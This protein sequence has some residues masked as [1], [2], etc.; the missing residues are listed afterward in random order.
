MEKLRFIKKV[1]IKKKMYNVLIKTFET[2]SSL[3]VK[4]F[5]ILFVGK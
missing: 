3:W 1:L 5:Q 2:G 4:F